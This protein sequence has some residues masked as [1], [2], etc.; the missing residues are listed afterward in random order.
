MA[1]LQILEDGF[2]MDNLV[3]YWAEKDL[4]GANNMGSKWEASAIAQITNG[5]SCGPS[6]NYVEQ[7][8]KQL[9]WGNQDCT[10]LSLN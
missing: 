9:W 6:V 1:P 8:S 7:Q 2:K 5:Q 10:H 3:L 4:S